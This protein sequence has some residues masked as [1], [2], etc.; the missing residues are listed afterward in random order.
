MM[1]GIV[2]C[3]WSFSRPVRTVNLSRLRMGGLG[4]CCELHTGVQVVD[5]Y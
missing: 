1:R 3:K 2:E 4:D 5:S